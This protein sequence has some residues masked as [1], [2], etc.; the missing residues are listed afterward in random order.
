MCACGWLTRAGLLRAMRICMCTLV[1]GSGLTCHHASVF[2]ERI[3]K[4]WEAGEPTKQSVILWNKIVRMA[5]VVETGEYRSAT[6]ALVG[7]LL[8]P[9][10]RAMLVKRP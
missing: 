4:L 3:F 10:L 9:I 7:S 8:M 2:V 1:A 6:R 5:A